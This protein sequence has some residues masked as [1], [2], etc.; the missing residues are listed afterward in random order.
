MSAE[1]GESGLLTVPEL[2]NRLRVKAS[3]IYCHVDE[4][5]AIR[6]GKYLR[7]SWATVMNRLAEA[8][9]R[10]SS[11]NRVGVPAQRPSPRSIDQRG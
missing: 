11:Q 8:S 10:Q 5:G 7:F 1:P 2:A 9:D 3:W 6:L 4:L